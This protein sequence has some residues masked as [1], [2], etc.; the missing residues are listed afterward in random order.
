MRKEEKW[1]PHLQDFKKYLKEQLNNGSI[2]I[3]GEG[4]ARRSGELTDAYIKKRE[5][6]AANAKR[7]ISSVMPEKG[8]IPVC[9]HM[10]AA[11]SA[12][13]FC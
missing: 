12:C 6:S 2:Y 13:I 5:T 8:R 11:V 7:V 4:R 1:A 3:S 10:T 9:A